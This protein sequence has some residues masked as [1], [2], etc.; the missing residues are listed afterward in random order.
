MERCPNCGARCDGGEQCR[1]C[2]LGL[3]PLLAVEEAAERLIGGALVRL[4][5]GDA[6]G[7]LSALGRSR[8][9][10]RD[11]LSHI[12]LG[13]ARAEA[14]GEHLAGRSPAK[15]PLPSLAIRGLVDFPEWPLAPPRESA[16]EDPMG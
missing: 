15:S 5:Q 10:R 13:F 3:A 8:N 12:L 9:L 1:R 14:A 11:A 4:A 7:A 2:G 16:A 6:A